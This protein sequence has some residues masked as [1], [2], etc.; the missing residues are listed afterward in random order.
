LEKLGFPW[1][2][3]SESSLFNGLRAIFDGTILP[4]LSGR[5]GGDSRSIER[6]ASF[7]MPLSESDL[8]DSLLQPD[9]VVRQSRRPS[10]MKQSQLFGKKMS[11]I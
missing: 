11:V 3:S 10:I 7:S 2:L 5:Q 6:F 9:P 1:I 8:R 4:S